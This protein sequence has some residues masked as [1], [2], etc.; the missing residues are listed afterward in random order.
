MS[1]WTRF[2]FHFHHLDTEQALVSVQTRVALVGLKLQQN[3]RCPAALPV[4]LVAAVARTRCHSLAPGW[5]EEP[6]YFFVLPPNRRHELD[7]EVG[8]GQPV[9]SARVPRKAMEGGRREPWHVQ[10]STP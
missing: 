2:R 1:P 4:W 6:Y 5:M 10:Y 7:C 9:A 3:R 8:V